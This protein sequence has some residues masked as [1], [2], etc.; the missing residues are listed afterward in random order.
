MRVFSKIFLV[1]SICLLVGCASGQIENVQSKMS[2]QEVLAFMKNR[3]FNIYSNT[4]RVIYDGRTIYGPNTPK[5]EIDLEKHPIQ[6]VDANTNNNVESVDF[7]K[8]PETNTSTVRV[9]L[10][11]AVPS[12]KLKEF[13]TTEEF[14]TILNNALNQSLLHLN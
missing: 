1:L 9:Y 7:I 13:V 3:G 4:F 14:N 8:D 2:D 12:D 10:N 5:T 11:S 6:I